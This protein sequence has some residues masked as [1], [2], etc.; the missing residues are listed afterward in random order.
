MTTAGRAHEGE[1]GHA[2]RRIAVVG[3]GG[4]EHALARRLASDPAPPR[5]VLVPGNDGMDVAAERIAAAI[6]DVASLER[7]CVAANAD[8]IVIGPEGPLAL[9]L[10]DRLRA[11]GIA[12][13]GPSAA[14]ARIESSKAFAKDVMRAAGVPTAPAEIFRDAESA[15]AALDRFG[16]PWV[17]KADGLAAGKGV[18]VTSRRDEASAF[19]TACLAGGRLGEAGRQI[20][21]ERHLVGEELSVMAITD[22]ERAVLLP[23]ARDYKRAGDGDTGPNTGGMGAY[24]PAALDPADEAW[25]RERVVVPTLAELRRRGAEFRGVLYAGLIRT[26]DG[27]AVIEFNARFGDPETQVVLPLVGG[28]L[29]LALL[30]AA[31]GRLDEAA[32]TRRDGAVVAVAIVDAAYP[33][34]PSGMATLEA[35]SLQTPGSDAWLLAAGVAV[36][37]GAWRITGGRAAYA[38]GR[39]ATPSTARDRAYALVDALG[40]A[41]WRCRRDI[42]AGAGPAASASGGVHLAA[43]AGAR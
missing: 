7:A 15:T 31:S 18:L 21:L 23:A 17:V 37:H 19:V 3:A 27:F 4:R 22:G 20:L 10:A 8:L 24:A 25:V 1:R 16:P 13:F 32:L 39:G 11:R 38:C 33:G 9:G 12:V 42:A 36:E 41:G 6:D 26:R 29:T 5:L 28:S 35:P 14:A 43:G 34:P 40:G 30:G 2:V